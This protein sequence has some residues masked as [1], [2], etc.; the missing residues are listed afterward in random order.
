MK[1]LHQLSKVYYGFQFVNPG[2][3]GKGNFWENL[4]KSDK[5]VN[6]DSS[7]FIE[8]K[9]LFLRRKHCLSQRTSTARFY[10]KAEAFPFEEK[11]GKYGF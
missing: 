2:D 6:Q 4:R 7:T 10:G 1:F 9:N 5:N 3:F 8:F 11:L